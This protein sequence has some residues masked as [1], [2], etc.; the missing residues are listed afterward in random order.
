MRRVRVPEPNERLIVSVRQHRHEQLSEQ[1][2]LRVQEHGRGGVDDVHRVHISVGRDL[3]EEG[4][5]HVAI[6][7]PNRLERREHLP[8][9]EGAE[10]RVLDATDGLQLREEDFV[11][12]LTLGEDRVHFGGS[13]GDGRRDIGVRLRPQPLVL[14]LEVVDRAHIVVRKEHGVLRRRRTAACADDAKIDEHGE[15]GEVVG[16]RAR[17]ARVQR[18]GQRARLNEVLACPF[19]RASTQHARWR[20][21]LPSSQVQVSPIKIDTIA[22]RSEDVLGMRAHSNGVHPRI[23]EIRPLDLLPLTIVDRV[24]GGEVCVE[25]DDVPLAIE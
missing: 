9:S 13:G 24:S 17:L 11:V 7:H 3:L 16:A 12:L 6:V 22:F 18:A 1:L 20:R 4:P 14:L 23:V 19:R 5:R 2:R 25:L 10:L 8:V 21:R 15:R